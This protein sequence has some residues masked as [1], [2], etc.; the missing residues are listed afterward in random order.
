VIYK[1]V[2]G[3]NKGATDSETAT[4]TGKKVMEHHCSTARKLLIDGASGK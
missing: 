4:T 2:F 3:F 1:V